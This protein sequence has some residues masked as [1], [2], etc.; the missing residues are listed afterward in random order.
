MGSPCGGLVFYL[1]LVITC[2]LLICG[3]LLVTFGSGGFLSMKR[4]G[5][6]LLLSA[7]WD[8]SPLQGYPTALNFPV[9]VY[10]SGWREASRE[11]SALAEGGHHL[12]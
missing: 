3:L 7:G 9:S 5:V 8:T 2:I 11:S 1:C 12:T 10:A 4:L 6:F